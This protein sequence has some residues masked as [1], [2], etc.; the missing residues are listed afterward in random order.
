MH[1]PYGEKSVEF[2]IERVN[3]IADELL[4]KGVKALVIACNTATLYAIEQL[5]A[6]LNAQLN[7]PIIGVEPAIK[8]AA[9]LSKSKKVALLVTQ[10]T[11]ESQRFQTLINDYKSNAE[12]FIQPCPG[13]VEIIE[14]GQ[15]TSQSC[16]HLL[17]RYIEPLINQGIDTLVLGCTH[18]PFLHQQIT[19]II[20]NSLTKQEI[21]LIETATPVSLQLSNKLAQA[22]L[23]ASQAQQGEYQFFSSQPSKQQ[24]VLIST[25]W[26]TQVNLQTLE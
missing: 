4:K 24:A 16:Q 10:A 26:Q 13:L 1:A 20:Q 6:R 19:S 8:P 18:Y 3:F 25:L 5:R 23:Y 15:H 22:D 21:K 7:I 9:K 11:S 17:T 12:V 14:K 2:I